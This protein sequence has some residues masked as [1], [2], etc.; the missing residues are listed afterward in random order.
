MQRCQCPAKVPRS[1]L[2]DITLEKDLK[3]NIR[4]LL[5]VK[6]ML[7]V[8]YIYSLAAKVVGC[9][10]ALSGCVFFGPGPGYS[11]AIENDSGVSIKYCYWPE[12]SEC[13]QPFRNGEGVTHYY[14]HVDGGERGALETFRE[15]AL[16]ICGRVVSIDELEAFSPI[17]NLNGRDFQMIIGEQVGD[18][19]CHSPGG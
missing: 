19:Y 16:E 9:A 2:C 4:E 6:A 18:V 3:I 12:I 13:N 14:E 11:L 7:K 10:L 5:R 17:E 15:R 8:S 1:I